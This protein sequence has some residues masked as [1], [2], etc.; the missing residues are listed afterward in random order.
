MD[1]IHAASP[2]CLMIFGGA[3]L[4]AIRLVYGVHPDRSGSVE[5]LLKMIAATAIAAGWLG[6]LLL[7]AGMAGL[8]LFVASLVVAQMT[9]A[10]IHVFRQRAL[11]DLLA[12]A[13]EKRIPLT[14]VVRAYAADQPPAARGRLDRL[15]A[16]LAAGMSLGQALARTRSL[17]PRQAL[18]AATVGE[19]TGG[20]ES[21]LRQ[22]AGAYAFG[23]PLH[24]APWAHLLPGLDG[25]PDSSDL[26]L[27]GEKDSAGL[28]GDLRGL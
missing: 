26:R 21:A 5:L 27:C 15:G 2:V 19:R 1:E 16:D 20:T 7:M 9:L 11:V 23:L 4:L 25:I 12:L 14:A 17:V 24:Q 3:L 13:M 8:V 10:Q 18:L 22:A 6:L 28:R